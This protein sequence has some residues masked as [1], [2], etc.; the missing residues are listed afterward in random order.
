MPAMTASDTPAAGLRALLADRDQTAAAIAAF[1]DR[2]SHDERVAAIRGLGRSQLQA[3]FARVA[4]YAELGLEDLVPKG[5]PDFVPIRHFGQNSLPAFTHFEKRFYR[6]G[7]AAAVGGANFQTLSV[8][9]GPG[10]FVAQR[11]PQKPEVLI[12][13]R[14]VPTQTPAGWPAVRGNESGVSRLVY[15]FMV[16]RLRR[17]SEHVSIGSASRNDKPVG[18]YFVLCRDASTTS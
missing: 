8:V 13:Y 18:A 15:G 6:M 14:R 4:G 9:T 5:T 7:D 17:V 2:L 16:D 10:Y 12:D 3:L 1:L 11:D